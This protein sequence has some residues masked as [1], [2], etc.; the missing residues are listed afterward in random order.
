MLGS[1][2]QQ[3]VLVSLHWINKQVSAYRH[4]ACMRLCVPCCVCVCVCQRGISESIGCDGGGC[5]VSL[6]CCDAEAGS[7]SEITDQTGRGRV[8]CVLPFYLHLT[9]LTDGDSFILPRPTATGS[10]LTREH[11]FDY[12]HVPSHWCL[13]SDVQHTLVQCLWNVLQ[14]PWSVC[15]TKQIMTG[16]LCWLTYIKTEMQTLEGLHHLTARLPSFKSNGS[17][18]YHFFFWKKIGRREICVLCCSLLERYLWVSDCWEGGGDRG[19]KGKQ[20]SRGGG[21]FLLKGSTD[22]ATLER[23]GRTVVVDHAALGLA[24]S[25]E[26]QAA[27]F[28]HLWKGRRRLVIPA[29]LLWLSLSKHIA[30]LAAESLTWSQICSRPNGKL[31]LTAVLLMRKGIF[32]HFGK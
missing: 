31:T 1:W 18:E 32:W 29:D 8:S 20:G 28:G 27:E 5:S 19:Q 16:H 26:E 10:L 9:L 4:H 21:F 24:L 7:R 11:R 6:S 13:N 14:P 17:K 3:S 15:L 25:R 30:S 22:R 23:L 12:L 2:Q